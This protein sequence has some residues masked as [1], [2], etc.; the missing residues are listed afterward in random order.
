[1]HPRGAK[2]EEASTSQGAETLAAPYVQ[3]VLLEHESHANVSLV[4][5]RH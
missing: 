5:N 1:M 2:A 3:E 4:Q